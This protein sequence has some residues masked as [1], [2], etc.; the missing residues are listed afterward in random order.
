MTLDELVAAAAAD[1]GVDSVQP[2]K[3]GGQKFVLSGIRS[4]E[5]V[6]LKVIAVGPGEG[7]QVLERARREV[8]LLAEVDDPRLVGLRSPIVALGPEQAP[9]GVAW[10]EERL[11]GVD[12]AEMLGG[13]PWSAAALV[14]LL[15]GVAALPPAPRPCSRPREPGSAARRSPLARAGRGRAG[16]T[17]GLARREWRRVASTWSRATSRRTGSGDAGSARVVEVGGHRRS[18]CPAP[19][20]PPCTRRSGWANALRTSTQTRPCRRSRRRA[21]RR[22]ADHRCPSPRDRAG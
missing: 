20:T 19:T 1:L 7:G 12:L 6:V 2:L 22:R 17:A 16:P 15:V 21:P 5:P 11:D 10:L 18:T 4:G 13:P 14:E 3:R 8:G 9:R